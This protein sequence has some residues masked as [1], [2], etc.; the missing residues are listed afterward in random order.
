MNV[1]VDDVF[2]FEQNGTGGGGDFSHHLPTKSKYDEKLTEWLYKCNR[3]DIR[4]QTKLYMDENQ[5]DAL[6][7]LGFESGQKIF[8]RVAC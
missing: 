3:S 2:D 7:K 1:K 5:L 4:G 6:E 8:R